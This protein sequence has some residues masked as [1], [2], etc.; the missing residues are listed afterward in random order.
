MRHRNALTIRSLS[1]TLRPAK[2]PWIFHRFS[3]STG[4]YTA[5]LNPT[6]FN[7]ACSVH[8]PL[9]H[10]LFLLMFPSL[11]SFENPVVF[12]SSPYYIFL[13]L[14][15]MSVIYFSLLHILFSSSRRA[16]FT[17]FTRGHA[18]ML[19][20]SND[21]FRFSHFVC[22]LRLECRIGTIFW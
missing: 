22:M 10:C 11:S 14:L 1:I 20:S 21:N 2:T 6:L 15:H 5:I 16:C 7:T 13:F 9:S 8:L 18:C 19:V 3:K 12:V 17:Y 4:K